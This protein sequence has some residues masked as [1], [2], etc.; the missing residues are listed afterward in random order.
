MGALDLDCGP[1]TVKVR[2]Q[3]KVHSVRVNGVEIE[4][5]MIVRPRAATIAGGSRNI[6]FRVGNVCQL[7]FHDNSCDVAHRHA[8]SMY[9]PDTQRALKELVCLKDAEASSP[10]AR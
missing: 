5:P 1:G 9:I 10:A 7:P 3:S 2:L 8:V 6:T 4:D